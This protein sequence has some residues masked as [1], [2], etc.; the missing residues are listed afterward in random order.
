MEA[1]IM[2]DQENGKPANPTVEAALEDAQALQE[3]LAKGIERFF[4]FSFY[5]NLSADSLGELEEA[6]KQLRTTLASLL[7]TAKTATLQMEEG[8]KSSIPIAQDRLYIARN[9]DTT[10]LASTFPFTSAILT[11]NKGIMYAC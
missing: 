11:Q 2:S 3:E 5:I 9:M 1:T 7:L 6:T 10:S 4:Q 8:F